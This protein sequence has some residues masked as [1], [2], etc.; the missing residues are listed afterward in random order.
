MITKTE[1]REHTVY[2]SSAYPAI[3]SE[4]HKDAEVIKWCDENPVVW[5]IVTGRK[6][7]TFGMHASHYIGWAQGSNTQDA[8]LA[9]AHEFMRCILEANVKRG[10]YHAL[11]AQW[12]MEH[13]NDKGFKTGFFIQHDGSPYPRLSWSHD[14]TPDTL[15]EVAERFVAWCG[16]LYGDMYD[17]EHYVTLHKPGKM[18]K[19]DP[20]VIVWKGVKRVD[21]LNP[22][23][24]PFNSSV[25]MKLNPNTKWHKSKCKL[26][27]GFNP[28][29]DNSFEIEGYE[30]DEVPGLFVHRGVTQKDGKIKYAAKDNHYVVTHKATS[31]RIVEKTGIQD[32]TLTYAQHVAEYLTCAVPAGFWLRDSFF[33]M[34][35]A[36]LDHIHNAYSKAA[37][38]TS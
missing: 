38:E 36:M 2:T 19:N 25:L 9:R 30:S 31:K 29:P 3:V 4:K 26:S 27:F 35:D 5:D 8:I 37:G 32:M 18:K 1:T 34:R 10:N 6:S 13:Y 17:G 16:F 12:T 24:F 22:F 11:R 21:M 33:G 14:Y 28:R 23:A 7:L 15:Q 20:G